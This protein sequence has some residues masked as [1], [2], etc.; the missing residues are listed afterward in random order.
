VKGGFLPLSQSQQREPAKRDAV[1]SNGLVATRIR[2]RNA[3]R[4][5]CAAR[6]KRAAEPLRRNRARVSWLA[7]ELVSLGDK[8]T[9]FASG[10]SKT[11]G[12]LVAV[13]PKPLRLSRPPIDP[14]SALTAQLECVA[15]RANEF[16][17]IHCHLDW[18]H[19]PLFRRLGRPFVTTLHGRLDLPHM[20]TFAAGFADAPFVSI[21]NNQ[22][23]PLAELNFVDTIY[24]GLPE[25]LLRANLQPGGYLAFLGRFTPEKGPH[26]AIRLARQAHLPLR[27]AAKIPRLQTRYFKEQIEPLLDGNRIE[28][29]GEVN[30][31]QKRGVSRQCH[32]GAFPD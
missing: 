13:S 2:E 6:R 7:D 9:L 28:F 10:G 29:V 26:V 20:H 19:I 16:D 24:H 11:K 32:G 30:D 5:N 8:V 3:Y 31:S 1:V 14:T 21:S 17:V 23:T 12:E 27:I 4:R 18:I 15:A 22:R 25:K